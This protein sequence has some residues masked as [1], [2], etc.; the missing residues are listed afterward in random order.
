MHNVMLRPSI[1][2]PQFNISTHFSTT[3]PCE[4]LATEK[5]HFVKA[6]YS[7]VPPSS[8]IKDNRCLYFHQG[9]TIEV[10]GRHESGWWD[11]RCGS[12]RGWFP[13]TYVGATL[14]TS[15]STTDLNLLHGQNELQ[16]SETQRSDRDRSLC[17]TDDLDKEDHTISALSKSMSQHALHRIEEIARLMT[18]LMQSEPTKHPSQ[19]FQLAI[20]I[21]SL[22]SLTTACSTCTLPRHRHTIYT[23]LHE[24]VTATDDEDCQHLINRLW[25]QLVLYEEMH[26][27]TMTQ[28]SHA[29]DVPSIHHP[30]TSASEG[31]DP[32]FS[33]FS[34][35]MN[36]DCMSA[37]LLGYKAELA[38][39]LTP[40]TD[41]K[42][43][44]ITVLIRKREVILKAFNDLAYTLKPSA[45]SDDDTNAQANG[46]DHV[47]DAI[48][49]PIPP[50]S[51]ARSSS[52]YDSSNSSIN[53]TDRLSLPSDTS[54]SQHRLSQA[55]SDSGSR[56]LDH[57]HC[58]TLS[59]GDQAD[60]DVPVHPLRGSGPEKEFKMPSLHSSP[61]M[62]MEKGGA[63][64]HD[65]YYAVTSSVPASRR[66]S[67]SQPLPLKVASSVELRRPSDKP[68]LNGAESS[69]TLPHFETWSNDKKGMILNDQGH[70]LGATPEVLVQVLTSHE[71][72]A[73]SCDTSVRDNTKTCDQLFTEAFFYHFRNFTDPCTLVSLLRHRFHLQPCFPLDEAE[74]I[75][76]ETNIL[77]PIRRQVVN[78]LITWLAHYFN[79]EKDQV[80]KDA[81]LTLI[82]NDITPVMPVL[83]E[84]LLTI[85]N[86]KFS[87][88]EAAASNVTDD[89]ESSATRDTLTSSEADSTSP[90]VKPM[91]TAL[92][93][94]SIILDIFSYSIEPLEMAK[95]LTIAENAL[96]CQI[97]PHK[98]MSMPKS[99]LSSEKHVKALIQRS[100]YLV[101]WICNTILDEYDCKKRVHNL[102]YWIT[103]AENCLQLQ[104][105][106][107]LMCIRCALNSAALSRLKRTWDF[108]WRS[109]K[110]TAIYKAI[111][112]VTSSERNYA[113]YRSCLR[114]ATTPCLPFLGIFLSDMVFI[115]DGN[116]DLRGDLINFD[117]YMK[118][119]RIL[120][121]SIIAFQVPYSLQS[122][123]ED[124]RFI[125][126]CLEAVSVTQTDEQMLYSKSLEIEPKADDSHC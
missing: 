45:P 11:G 125:N 31:D 40:T 123:E 117:K 61:S 53:E 87:E 126:Q 46:Q 124:Q 116:P 20:Q 99:K 120:Y 66:S 122:V 118:M 39:L 32:S 10:L 106:N 101:R 107:T 105:Y 88:G 96:F 72:I 50:L 113:V 55:S 17:S 67:K 108:I 65:D 41:M 74:R 51:T 28:S 89:E 27:A 91:R 22:L 110:Y 80:M 77:I 48:G 30:F 29:S 81:L 47:P 54:W 43:E 73:T 75:T 78:A 115:D 83:A 68:L 85:A 9:D 42:T 1:P 119:T 79:Y 7:F 70:I 109:T 25:T 35:S 8:S 33:V 90:R 103:V 23:T 44:H 37:L 93:K 98:L 95:Q 49:D 14:E 112:S 3:I 86:E 15:S 94:K 92:R 5:G 12:Q 82:N 21:R 63:V 18:L 52:V 56:Y 6:L 34:S 4:P 114:R 58:R 26:C 57:L 24:L 69:D 16:Q 2:Q 97:E 102:K 121:D 71:K 38:E 64:S 13:S 60:D 59:V 62:A 76:W 19:L 111:D 100:T 104:N 84:R 36:I